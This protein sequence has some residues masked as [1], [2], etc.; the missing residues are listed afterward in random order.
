MPL[1]P[2][3]TAVDLVVFVPVSRHAR[4]HLLQQW[5]APFNESGLCIL[6]LTGLGGILPSVKE[7]LQ[8][9]GILAHSLWHLACI[10]S[11]NPILTHVTHVFVHVG[12]RTLIGAAAAI[13]RS[14]YIGHGESDKMYS[15]RVNDRRPV[16]E[17]CD[18][19]AAR[20]EPIRG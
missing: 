19:P 8:A 3:Q 14:V 16:H 15:L 4:S 18:D 2:H 1:D 5:V 11:S 6:V 17:A 9:E 10:Y 20:V 7:K 12:I 13:A